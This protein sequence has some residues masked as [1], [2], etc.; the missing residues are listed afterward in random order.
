[1]VVLERVLLV[2]TCYREREEERRERKYIELHFFSAPPVGFRGGDH[3]GIEGIGLYQDR[4]L[5][6]SKST[7]T[8]VSNTMHFQ[9]I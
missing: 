2:D 6:Q 3:T 4:R 5:H 8:R 7:N 1:M 9:H